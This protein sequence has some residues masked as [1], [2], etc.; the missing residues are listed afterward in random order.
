MENDFIKKL[1]ASIKLT[2]IFSRFGKIAVDMGFIT[3]EQLKEAITEQVEDDLADKPHRLIGKILLE[4]GWITDEQINI[5]LKENSLK[6]RSI[7]MVQEKA[8]SNCR[9][10]RM[11]ECKH[12]DDEFLMKQLINSME[13]NKYNILLANYV[14]ESRCNYCKVFKH[15]Q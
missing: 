9:Y 2:T 7:K 14:N 8:F 3:A 11:P 15:R 1:T 10:F 6:R 4:N 13:N 12:S 5:A